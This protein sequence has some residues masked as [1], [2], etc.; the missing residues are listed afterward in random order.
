MSGHG[1]CAVIDHRKVLAVAEGNCDPEFDGFDEVAPRHFPRLV[2]VSFSIAA[3]QIRRFRYNAR[4]L[5]QAVV[6]LIDRVSKSLGNVLAERDLL[7]F[8][9]GSFDA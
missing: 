4:Y 3:R 5:S 7:I 9:H 6:F 1:T 8:F 2:G